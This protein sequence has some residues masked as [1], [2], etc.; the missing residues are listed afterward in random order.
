[1]TLKGAIRKIRR[2]GQGLQSFLPGIGT[3]EPRGTAF[4]SGSVKQFHNADD[5]NYD[6][7]ACY[8]AKSGE[9]YT[10]D[11]GDVLTFSVRQLMR[12]SPGTFATILGMPWREVQALAA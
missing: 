6:H 7:S 3:V 10:K 5:G 8:R 1:M 11:S 2:N 12:E 4:V 9:H